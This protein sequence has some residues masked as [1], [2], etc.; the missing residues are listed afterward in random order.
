MVYLNILVS[1]EDSLR[2]PSAG[3]LGLVL[4][5]LVASRA[6]LCEE[7]AAITKRGEDERRIV[8]NLEHAEVER[9][10]GEVGGLKWKNAL[11]L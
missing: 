7:G 11:N 6:V 5:S 10:L 2:R 9:V 4:E 1:D 8:M 3:E